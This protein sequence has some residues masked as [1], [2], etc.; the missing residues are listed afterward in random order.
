MVVGGLSGGIRY[1]EGTSYEIIVQRETKVTLV[2]EQMVRSGCHSIYMWKAGPTGFV[3]GP[4]VGQGQE[5]L[6]MMLES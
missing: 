5:E 3:D 4:G 6:T 1:K 2:W